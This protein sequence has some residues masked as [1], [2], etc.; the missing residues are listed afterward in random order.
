MT[1]KLLSLIRDLARRGGRRR[2]GL[3]LA[4][5]VRLVEEALSNKIP[6]T[7]AA[8][9]PGLDSTERGSRIR[10][11]LVELQIPL[12]ELSDRDLAK[13]ATTEQPQG[14]IAVIEP[15]QWSLADIEFGPGPRAS[16]IVV[17]D[18]LQ[19]PGNVGAVVRTAWALGAAGVVALPGT[20]ELYSPKTLRGSMGA[21]FACPAV[22]CETAELIAWLATNEVSL[23][24]A[25]VAGT[26][27]GELTPPARVALA[28]GNEGAGLSRELSAAAGVRVSVPQVRPVES[29][30]VAV[31][32]GILLHEVTRER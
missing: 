3:T 15:P 16:P 18:A 11:A 13:L 23:W 32:A 7:G 22:R 4:E 6:V 29:L 21:L 26:P 20:A 28:L 12:L 5:G 25:E 30:N 24:L 2:R 9:A 17:L 27:I 14:I 31:A 1:Q 19:D 10:S 8:V